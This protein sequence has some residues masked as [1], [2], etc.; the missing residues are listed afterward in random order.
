MTRAAEVVLALDADNHLGETPVWSVQDQALWWVN[1]EQPAQIHR[2]SPQTGSHVIWSM[3][4][5]VGGF[6]IKSKGGLLVALS[7]GLYDFSPASGA[8]SLRVASPLPDHVGLHE[9]QCDRQGRLWVG[10][11]DH[12]YPADRSASGAGYFRLDGD[13]LV[14]VVDG[15]AVAN[16]LAVSPDGRTLYAHPSPRRDVEAFDLNADTGALSNRRTFLTLEAGFG[17]IDGATVDAEG[18]YWLAVVGAG[19]LRRYTPDG[20]L[21]LEIGLPFSNPTKPAFGGPDMKTLYVT[22]TRLRLGSNGPMAAANGGLF[23]LRPGQTGV[24]D[25]LFA[26]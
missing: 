20:V 13:Q 7:D 4:K 26:G 25:T 10:G 11:F 18:G 12:H 2:W 17:F 24:P 3:P 14:K 9:C 16:G 21:D 8:V 15:V 22:S 23:S 6:V 5:R 1:C 19:V